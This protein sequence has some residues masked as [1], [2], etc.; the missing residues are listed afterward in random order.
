MVSY[1]TQQAILVELTCP[2]E[3]GIESASL[4]KKARYLQLLA[5]I[6]DD[7]NNPWSISLF[8]VEGGARGFVAYSMLSFLRKIGMAPRKAKSLCKKIS[9]IL[10]RCSYAIFLQRDTQHWDANKKLLDLSPPKMS[11]S[12]PKLKNTPLPDLL[13]NYEE[14]VKSIPD[15]PDNYDELI[16]FE[17]K[18][19]T[20]LWERYS[21]L[22]PNRPT[23]VADLL[24]IA[25]EDTF[26]LI[27]LDDDLFE[28]LLMLNM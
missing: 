1:S 24:A 25:V 18:F 5:D 17:A 4:R 6:N 2:A 3:E 12:P 22:G 13:D 26:D 14:L 9:S 8:T 27:T 23:N 10:A 15:I 21:Y 11:S 19:E 28:L 20:K 16:K 7:P